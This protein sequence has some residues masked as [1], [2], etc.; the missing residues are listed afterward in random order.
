MRRDRRRK[1]KKREK[2]IGVRKGELRGK[3]AVFHANPGLGDTGSF[4]KATVCEKRI[5][6]TV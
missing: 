6:F 1:E 5:L 4:S 2:E 3:R